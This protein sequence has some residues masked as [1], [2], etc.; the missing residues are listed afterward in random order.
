MA[1]ESCNFYPHKGL[2]AVLFPQEESNLWPLIVPN[3]WLPLFQDT[4]HHIKKVKL[5]LRHKFF[6]QLE[7]NFMPVYYYACFI[8]TCFL[9]CFS[10]KDIVSTGALRFNKNCKTVI[11]DVL[12]LTGVLCPPAD[13]F[14]NILKP[15]WSHSVSASCSDISI[16][17]SLEAQKLL[18]L[19]LFK[20]RAELGQQV[21]DS[22]Q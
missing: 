21:F 9:H 15:L 16:I 4:W 12:R 10:V 3:W 8:F 6:F 20:V 14:N 7:R 5:K 11:A 2:F 19:S 17:K 18:L 22:F 1:V 13:V